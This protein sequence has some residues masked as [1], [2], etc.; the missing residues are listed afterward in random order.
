MSAYTDRYHRVAAGFTRRVDAVPAEAWER[1]APCEGWVA[2]DVVGHLVEW[3]PGFL[4]HFAGI[5][6]AD[7]STATDDPAAAW[8]ALDTAITAVLASPMPAERSMARWAR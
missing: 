7:L 3:V 8:H 4:S 5:S 1:P 6:V 2:R